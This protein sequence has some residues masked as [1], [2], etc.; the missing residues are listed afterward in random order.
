V[1]AE[2]SRIPA[3]SVEE[4]LTVAQP[5]LVRT[6]DPLAASGAAVGLRAT[7]EAVE[8]AVDALRREPG[9]VLIF[10]TG[11][12]DPGEA[13]TQAR[14]AA[15][16]ARVAGM[17]GTG[18]ITLNGAI[19]TGCAAI[20]F[21]SALPVG[22]GTSTSTDPRAA[23]RSAAIEALFGVD[24]DAGHA[25]LLL[26]VDSES[27]DQAE[28]IAGAYEIAGGRIPL[29]G[30][31]AGG[32]VRAQFVDGEPL[33][34]SVVAVALVSPTPIGVGIGHGCVPRGAPSIVTRSRGRIVL[35]LDGRPAE[36][37]YLEKLGMGDVPLSDDDFEAIA[38]AHPLAQPELRG[39][40][41]PR[42]VRGRV[43]GGGLVCATDI[44]ANA[45]VDVCEQKPEATVRSALAAV[46]DAVQ[47]L[48]GPAEAVLLFDCAAR[49]ARFGNPL[50]PRE[51]ESIISSFGD[52]PP[53]LAGVYTRGE[54]GRVR[55]AKGDRNYSLVVVAIGSTR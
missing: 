51:V 8:Q 55:G 21:E 49:S 35:Q 11:V 24:A 33:S 18:A 30:G 10:P 39:D 42:Y 6:R 7:F 37:V 28:V 41:R 31:A 32:D 23:G 26:F 16:R 12:L 43:P 3:S 2:K 54:I 25:A 53:A 19:E 34:G 47:Q 46:G 50:A 22:V 20:A 17:T 5:E 14:A 48:E 4:L 52:P 45:A 36:A 13:A 9:L 40:V 29:A 27:G 1:Q 44:E 38:M 15:G